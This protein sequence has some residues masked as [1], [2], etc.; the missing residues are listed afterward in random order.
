LTFV[1]H[2]CGKV[3]DDLPFDFGFRYPDPYFGVAES[4]RESR[5]VL[6]AD[7]CV[8]DGKEFYVRGY[9]P[10]PI[11]DE[12]PPRDQ[13]RWGV[14]V[15]LSKKSFDNYLSFS[16]QTIPDGTRYFGWLCNRIA[17]YPETQ[18]LKCDVFPQRDLRPI[19]R[20]QACDHPL[21]REQSEGV[22]LKRVHDFISL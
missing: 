3:H 4:E 17:G 9:I 10:I 18:G 14:W 7:I 11:R 12:Q 21:Y 6:N 15:S 16:G 19:V 2:A 13:F 5:I 8:I 22:T 1:C 20:L